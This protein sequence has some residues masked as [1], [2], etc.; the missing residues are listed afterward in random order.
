M[1]NW[2]KELGKETWKLKAKDDVKDRI[3]IIVGDD[4]QDDFIPQ[5]KM[6][7]WDNEVNFSIRL[8]TDKKNTATLTNKK[9]EWNGDNIGLEWFNVDA[10]KEYPEGAYKFEYI[11]NSKPLSNHVEFSI[12]SKGLNFYKQL[13]LTQVQIDNGWKRPENV[14][15]SYAI[16]CAD[17]KTNFENGKIYRSGKFGH[18]FRPR[19]IDSDGNWTW[20]DLDIDVQNKTYI[21]TIPQTFLDTAVY[22]IRSNDTF[23]YTSIGASVQNFNVGIFEC[24]N[25]TSGIAGVASSIKICVYDPNP[26][27]VKLAIYTSD[28]TNADTLVAN[29]SSGELTITRT[30]KPTTDAHWTSGS[31]S[32]SISATTEYFLASSFEA[33]ATQYAFDSGDNNWDYYT[34][35][36]SNFPPGDVGS[37]S[38][39]SYY[40]TG[41]LYVTYAAAADAWV[42]RVI[43]ID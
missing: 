36:Y 29:S 21:V 2:E 22:P 24:E 6:E 32:A 23:G 16:Y 43:F 37:P 30:T 31:I 18:I 9:I 14:I 7:R 13:P 38:W 34:L 41:S 25:F 12:T 40:I 20:G 5:I 28:G 10:N 35:A 8:I 39:A 19:I 4:K 15:N 11:I 27:G 1:A 3:D 33:N 17:K 26:N 42:P